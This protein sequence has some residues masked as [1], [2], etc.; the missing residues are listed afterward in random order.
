M[1][2]AT[3]FRVGSF[4]SLKTGIQ[5]YSVLSAGDTEMCYADAAL[6]NLVTKLHMIWY[7]PQRQALA[8]VAQWT[9]C[10]PVNQRVTSLIFSQGHMPGL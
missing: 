9:E 8:G 4:P 2:E 1:S 3:V 6:E 10:W 7:E 5:F